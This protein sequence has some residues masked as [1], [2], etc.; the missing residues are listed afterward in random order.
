MK[1]HRKKRKKEDISLLGVG[2]KM[3]ITFTPIIIIFG[4]LNSRFYSIFKIP[5][6]FYW[7]VIIGSSLIILG[8]FIFLKSEKIISSAFKSSKLEISKTYAYVRHPMYASWGLGTF[9]GIL[10]FFNSWFLFLLLPMYYLIVR[11][12]IKKEEDFMLK[13]YGKDYIDYK[14]NVNAFFPK[15][16]RYKPEK[17]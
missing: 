8:L 3:L 5:I 9:P 17:Q 13:K 2:P 14:N 12:Y 15:P 1:I 7:M 6:E 4:I 16:K 10:C 11:I